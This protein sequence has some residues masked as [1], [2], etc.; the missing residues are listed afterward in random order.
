ML[1]ISGDYSD[2]SIDDWVKFYH[3]IYKGANEKRQPALLWL[4]AV[5][6][7]TKL[8]EE[9]RKEQPDIIVKEV[10]KLF[11]WV[12][13]F[14]G[15]YTLSPPEND[16][17]PIG[18]LLC[19]KDGDDHSNV[20]ESWGKWVWKKYPG[21]CPVCGQKKCVCP[22]Y[23]EL[24]EERH[25]LEENGEVKAEENEHEKAYR[26]R[27]KEEMEEYRQKIEKEGRKELQKARQNT[28]ELGNF[29]KKSLDKQID[30]LITI[31]G[32]LHFDLGFLQITAKLLEEV[33]EVGRIILALEGL[34]D[35][36]KQNEKVKTEARSGLIKLLDNA[37]LNDERKKELKEK[38]NP[39]LT[40]AIEYFQFWAARSLKGELADVFTWLSAVLHKVGMCWRFSCEEKE[41]Q[42]FQFY[43][44][45]IDHHRK[46]DQKQL[47]CTFCGKTRCEKS[48]LWLH[49][50]DTV[51]EEMA[52][53]ERKNEGVR[54]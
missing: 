50:C 49:A 29:K 4:E 46:N 9:A 11:S 8:T 23:R 30:M 38:V 43:D 51:L 47:V 28:T 32:G 54:R 25:R 21:L 39:D 34:Y 53:E 20:D 27:R 48:C 37:K 6:E 22:A 2:F 12:C 24:A 33:G 5:D 44:F 35:L 26:A 14:I 36:N 19:D 3:E 31:Y 13:S 40:Q 16:K 7:A 1:D 18:R 15:K 41:S 45:L 52:K 17:D 42:W 10:V